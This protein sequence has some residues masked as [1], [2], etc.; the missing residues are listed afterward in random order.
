MLT[1]EEIIRTLNVL[2]GEVQ[3]RFHVRI[4]GIF[5][6]YAANRHDP[7]SDLDVLVEFESQADMF[8]LV[9]LGDFLKERLGVDVDIVPSR[10]IRPELRERI[11][12][13]AIML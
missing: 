2:N 10:S 1:L 3:G 12:S 6:S 8:D 13:E 5:G 11:L 4:K 7:D 9:A